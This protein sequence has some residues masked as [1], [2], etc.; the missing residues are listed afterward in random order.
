MDFS[1]IEQKYFQLRPELYRFVLSQ[2]LDRDVT[3][4]TMQEIIMELIRV[5]RQ[6]TI[7]REE[8]FRGFL[9][10]IAYSKIK[11]QKNKKMKEPGSFL[12]ALEISRQTYYRDIRIGLDVLRRALE[13]KG[14]TPEDLE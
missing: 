5:Y 3:E 12:Q 7:I 6:G 9:Y 10:T 2:I 13:A 14:L 8:T 4:D 1:E 11:Q